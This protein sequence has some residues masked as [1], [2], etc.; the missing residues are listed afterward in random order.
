MTKELELYNDIDNNYTLTQLR[1]FYDKYLYLF[2]EAKGLKKLKKLE[3]SKTYLINLMDDFFSSYDNLQRFFKLVPSTVEKILIQLVCEGSTIDAYEAEK[4]YKT[5]IIKNQSNINSSN[6][7]LHI[8]NPYYIFSIKT[9]NSYR[10]HDD[11]DGHDY[12]YSFSLPKSIRKMI[13]EYLPVPEKYQLKSYSTPEMISNMYENNDNILKELEIYKKF[14]DHESDKLITN[15]RLLKSILKSFKEKCGVNEFYQNAK[16]EEWEYLKSELIITFLKAS[17]LVPISDFNLKSLKKLFHAY[18]SGNSLY[19]YNLLYHL[20]NLKRKIEY[21]YTNFEISNAVFN[22]NI[23]LLLKK[24]KT[25]EWYKF[26]DVFNYSKYNE[27][28]FRIIN[29]RDSNDIYFE[30]MGKYATKTELY[31]NNKNIYDLAVT[32]PLLK[33]TF[34]LLSVFGILN[35]CYDLP[36]NKKV[37]GFEKN[38]LSVFDG[39]TYIKLTDLGSYII[40]KTESYQPKIENVEDA[41]ITLD[42]NELTIRAIGKDKIKTIFLKKYANQISE[43]TYKV[44]YHSFLKEC[45]SQYEL[46]RKITLFKKEINQELPEIWNDFLKELISKSKPLEENTELKIYRLKNDKQLIELL[47]KDEFLKNHVIKVEKL[48]IGIEKKDIARVRKRLEQ[49]GYIGSII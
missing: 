28:D 4:E 5:N 2:D 43:N 11:Y 26:N 14:I 17:E 40:G 44:D 48:Q 1:E 13:K 12:K 24:L 49:F 45:N 8:E 41:K 6:L 3:M 30:V 38:Y 22:S 7:F 37:K 35:I 27:F 39:L 42:E 10:Y 31:I 20:K 15:K 19:S 16:S 34:F 33:A 25:D 9:K 18:Q 21:G 29:E 23:F 46:K 36:N 47:L 32:Q